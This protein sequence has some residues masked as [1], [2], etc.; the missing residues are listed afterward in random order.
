MGIS[1]PRDQIMR[2]VTH[3]PNTCCTTHLQN[4]RADSAKHRSR[5]QRE[6][7]GKCISSTSRSAGTVGISFKIVLSLC[8][9]VSVKTNFMGTRTIFE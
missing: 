8:A 4:A 6:T 5:D 3:V 1:V 9:V 2:A 7:F